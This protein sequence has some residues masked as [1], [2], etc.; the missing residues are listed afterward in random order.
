MKKTS[1]I[2]MEDDVATFMRAQITEKL[3]RWGGV[4]M[5]Q[6]YVLTENFYANRANLTYIQY[7]YVE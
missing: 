5:C 3:S 4:V 2:V 7:T 6:C 1:L